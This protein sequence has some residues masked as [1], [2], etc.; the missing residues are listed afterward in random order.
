MI[1]MRVRTVLSFNAASELSSA[2]L[3]NLLGSGRIFAGVLPI[4]ADCGDTVITGQAIG[5]LGLF[6][7]DIKLREHETKGLRRGESKNNGRSF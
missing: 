6:R 5:Q 2:M 4:H 3:E 1:G 7:W